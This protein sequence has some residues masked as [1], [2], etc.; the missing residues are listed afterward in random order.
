MGQNKYLAGTCGHPALVVLRLRGG[1]DEEKDSSAE[2][3]LG[4]KALQSQADWSTSTPEGDE[5]LVNICF[6]SFSLVTRMHVDYLSWPES[7]APSSRIGWLACGCHDCPKYAA[8]LRVVLHSCCVHDRELQSL[9]A[10]E[11]VLKSV[12]LRRKI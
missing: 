4:V 1:E 2:G 12:C 6:I 3:G 11:S 10:P 7:R 8:G 9:P 5:E